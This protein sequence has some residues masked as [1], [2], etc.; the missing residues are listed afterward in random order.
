MK[1]FVTL[2]ARRYE[3]IVNGDAIRINGQ[4]HHARIELV[5]GMPVCH[6]VVD[7]R[8]H[9]VTQERSGPGRWA[10]RLGGEPVEIEVLDERADHIRGLVGTGRGHGAVG[11]IRAPM[12]GLVTKVQVEAGALVKAGQGL[13]VLEAMKMENELKAPAAG[14]VLAI[15]V[16]PG[17]AVEKGL[18][19]L[20]LGPAEGGTA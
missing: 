7:G 5:P 8:S 2:G 18:P 10:L 20:E 11:A 19:L 12:P 15:F 3:V 13:V 16:A 1:Y 9:T 6:L 17:Q 4:A 14:V